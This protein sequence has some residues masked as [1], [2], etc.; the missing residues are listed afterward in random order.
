MKLYMLYVIVIVKFMVFLQVK[1][2]NYHIVYSENSKRTFP[3][4]TS[5]MI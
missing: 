3:E 1:P 2:T 5:H 4:D